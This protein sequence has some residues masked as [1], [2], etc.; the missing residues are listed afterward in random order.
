[1]GHALAHTEREKTR[2]VVVNFFAAFARLRG[3]VTNRAFL[4]QSEANG[5]DLRRVGTASGRI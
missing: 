4:G 2:S 5:D 1:M 3:C